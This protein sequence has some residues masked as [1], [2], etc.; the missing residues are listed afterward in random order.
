MAGKYERLGTHQKSMA[1][2]Y[3]IFRTHQKQWLASM[4]DLRK[5]H[6]REAG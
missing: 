2:K 6:C 1:S 3:E 5:L 4:K